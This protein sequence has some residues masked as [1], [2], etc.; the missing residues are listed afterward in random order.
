[1]VFPGHGIGW[2]DFFAAF[3]K[4]W[5]RDKLTDIAGSLVF[6]G[7]LALFPFLLF[8]VTLAGLILKPD[9]VEGVIGQMALVAPRDVTKI[10]ADQI[11]DIHKGQNVGLLTL[12]FVGAI[13]SASGGVTSL[14]AALN[15]VY[16]VEEGRPF[17]KVRGIAVLATLGAGVAILLAVLAGV[18]AGPVADHL[19][20]PFSTA[21]TLLRLPVAGMIMMAVWASLYYLLPDVEQRFKFITPGSV[22]GVLVWVIASWGFSVYV[23]K[24]G[25]YNKTYGA[26]GGVI[27]LLMWMWISTIVLLI[28]AEV[29]AIIEHLSPEGKKT[30]AKSMADT[31]PDLPKTEKEEEEQGGRPIY[32]PVPAVR[33][34]QPAF[35]PPRKRAAVGPTLVGL[36]LLFLRHRRRAV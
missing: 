3:K 28:G 15:G 23:S 21:V 5:K 25:S 35:T 26:I 19:P 12:G 2:K 30:G 36:A 18:V 34:V 29:N 4:E 13:W 7:V 11:R 10:F 24:F 27:V 31:G 22:F 20:A 17:W 9:Q 8:L 1:M 33:L 14:M 32:V 6:F 16:A